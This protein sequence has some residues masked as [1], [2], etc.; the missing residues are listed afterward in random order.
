VNLPEKCLDI[1]TFATGAVRSS[2]AGKP[3]LSQLDGEMLRQTALVMEFGEAKYDRGNWRKGIP[4]NRCLDSLLR[5]ILAFK[6]GETLDPE[7]G[8]P[9]LGHA[10]CNIQFLLRYEADN[11]TDLDDRDKISI[12]PKEV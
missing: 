1:S 6:E 5:H 7:S 2:A 12:T 4:Y 8:L 10:A 3:P 9:H 11:R